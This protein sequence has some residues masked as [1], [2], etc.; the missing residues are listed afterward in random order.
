[1]SQPG[2][3]SLAKKTGQSGA[4]P[5]ILQLVEGLRLV[6]R[7]LEYELISVPM[8]DR[9]MQE[10]QKK[11]PGL[12]S[13]QRVLLKRQYAEE[14]LREGIQIRCLFEETRSEVR[15]AG[16][17]GAV[18]TMMYPLSVTDPSSPDDAPLKI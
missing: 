14:S 6:V 5:G 18:L 16:R 11:P 4:T 2:Q 9:I 8:F 7:S 17:R 3:L 15:R 1:M 13:S 12:P 10:F